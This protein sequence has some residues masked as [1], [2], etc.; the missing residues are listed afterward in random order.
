METGYLKI[1][2]I[3][4][5]QPTIEAQ[6][7]NNTLWL[8]VNEI[9]QLFDVY[10]NTIGNNLRSIFKSG[11]LYEENVSFTHRYTDKKGGEWQT[12]L[13]NLDAIIFVSYRIASPNAAIFRQWINDSFREH[14][15]K[16]DI[17]NNSKLFW[18]FQSG[19]SYSL[20]R[21]KLDKIP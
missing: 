1:S 21:I 10:V 6:L 5:G 13:Y 4:G 8:T 7:I 16:N 17:Q 18:T 3:E 12:V 14:L 9:A 2:N 15:K 20:S 11:L 19:K